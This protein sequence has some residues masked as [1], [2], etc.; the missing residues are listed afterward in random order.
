MTAQ[1][2]AYI[3]DPQ[4]AEWLRAAIAIHDT[5]T[6]DDVAKEINAGTLQ[7]WLNEGAALITEEHR[8]PRKKTLHIA[9]GGGKLNALLSLADEVIE[10]AKAYDYSGVSICGR[11]GWKRILEKR[12]WRATALHMELDT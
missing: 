10:I 7:L 6:L 5:H 12:G 3:H 4:I 9:L 2:G 11:I 1:A 8:T